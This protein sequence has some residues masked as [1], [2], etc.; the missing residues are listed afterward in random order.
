M[1]DEA[2]GPITGA[3]TDLCDWLARV[4]DDGTPVRAAAP[5][6]AADGVDVWPLELLADGG[7]PDGPIRLRL[8]HL[9]V[10]AGSLTDAV[11]VLDRVIVAVAG[12]DRYR[13]VFEPV[14]A[15]VWSTTGVAPRPVL[16]LDV[17][18]LVTRPVAPVPRVREELS[19]HLTPVHPIRGRV[20][21]PGA[22]PLPGITVTGAGRTTHTDPRGE[23]TLPGLPGNRAV[24]L[25]LS[26]RGLHLRA[27]VAAPTTEPVV[28][29]CDIEEV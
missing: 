14:P 16:V 25:H 4:L 5:A 15:H 18:I 28:I 20:V 11:T 23:F 7:S 24:P 26:G 8:R 22:V 6:S 10:P 13:P 21:G 2:T 12:D 17:P 1:T 9:V 3:L 29:H 27:E 19:L